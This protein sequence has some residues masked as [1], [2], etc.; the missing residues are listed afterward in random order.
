MLVSSAYLD[1]LLAQRP[2]LLS[3]CL[4]AVVVAVVVV[5]QEEQPKQVEKEILAGSIANAAWPEDRSGQ[6]LACPSPSYLQHAQWQ[7][8]E[9]VE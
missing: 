7:W 9:S 8:P 3:S 6:V 1:R 2:A 4:L 5:V